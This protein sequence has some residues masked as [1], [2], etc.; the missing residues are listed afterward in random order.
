[1]STFVLVHGAMHGGWC[2][3]EVQRRLE[4]AGHTVHTPTLTGQGE[5]RHLLTRD[6]GIATHVGD[7]TELLW[8]ED[9]RDVVLGVHSY[10]G[11]LAGPVVE[12]A[13]GRIRKVAYLGAFLTGSGE[14]L[15]DVE[16]EATAR[17]YLELADSAG[18]GWRV[19]ASPAFLDQWGVTDPDDRAWVGP[20]LTDFPLRCCKEPAVFS[21]DALAAVPCA[22]IRHT[23]PPLP[24]LERSWRR[25]EAGGAEMFDIASGHDMMIARPA[26]T[27]R[28]LEV[29]GSS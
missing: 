10:A 16:P 24:S 15:L 13:D 22:Y 8:F 28:L 6:V 17:R 7:L 23:D 3:R 26:E 21:P 27:A 29:I 1:M 9:L 5:R 25:A 12:Q 11:V 4:E 18:D 19:P 14:S 2:W 20:R